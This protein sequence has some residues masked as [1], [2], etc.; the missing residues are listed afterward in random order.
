MQIRS[1]QLGIKKGLRG[2][3]SLIEYLEP[4]WLRYLMG[5]RVRT[6]LIFTAALKSDR[7]TLKK[8]RTDGKRT[9]IVKFGDQK[10]SF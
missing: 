10:H 3:M 2:R 4:K 6:V 8:V 5:L 7:G 9:D 1:S